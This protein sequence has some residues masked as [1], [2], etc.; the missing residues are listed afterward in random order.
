MSTNNEI[1]FKQ[2]IDFNTYNA[3]KDSY[4]KQFTIHS[5]KLLY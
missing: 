3:I 5:N 1:E 4:F 2:L